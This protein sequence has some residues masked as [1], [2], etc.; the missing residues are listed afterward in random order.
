MDGDIGHYIDTLEQDVGE[1]VRHAHFW[2]LWSLYEV[3]ICRQN[4]LLRV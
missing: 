3:V 2:Q 4:F 1:A